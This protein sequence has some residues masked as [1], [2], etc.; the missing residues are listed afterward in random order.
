M[1]TAA[2]A[3]LQAELE[4]YS[5]NRTLYVVGFLFN[6]ALDTVVLIQKQKPAWQCGR[7]NGVG[8]KIEDGESPKAAMRREFKEETGLDVADWRVF[9]RLMGDKF[10]VHC[11]TAIGDT[12]K[13]R[14][15]ETEEVVAVPL[16]VLDRTPV[17]P[18]LRWLIPLALD[19]DRVFATVHDPS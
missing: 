4:N 6:T 14:T 5:D 9:C 2:T 3:S 1:I 10:S 15:M 8:G 7:F 13:V 11:F 17:I 12:S 19:N 18:N 16:S